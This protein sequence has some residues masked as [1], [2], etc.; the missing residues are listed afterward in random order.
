VIDRDQTSEA[1]TEI[2]PS[3]A[4][5]LQGQVLQSYIADSFEKRDDWISVSRGSSLTNVSIS[6]GMN[7]SVF[8]DEL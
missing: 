8:V 3:P 2:I 7:G 6:L 1:I 4:Q 5:G